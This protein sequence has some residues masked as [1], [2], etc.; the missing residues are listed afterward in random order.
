MNELNTDKMENAINVIG[1]VL[2]ILD[3][4][5]ALSNDAFRAIPP[6]FPA[7][8]DK[9][10]RKPIRELVEAAIRTVWAVEQFEKEI[11]GDIRKS[12]SKGKDRESE[13]RILRSLPGVHEQV[14]KHHAHQSKDSPIRVQHQSQSTGVTSP[15]P[16]GQY[17]QS[18]VSRLSNIGNTE[19]YSSPSNPQ[20]KTIDYPLGRSMI[21]G[22]SGSY[23]A[24]VEHPQQKNDFIQKYNPIRFGVVNAMSRRQNL[25]ISPV[26]QKT[27]DGD[28]YAI[29]MD[30]RNLYL[31]VPRFDLTFE[32]F[33]YGPGAMGQV[34]VCPN[35]DP[36]IHYR[37]VKVSEPAIFESDTAQKLWKVK[38]KGK[39]DLS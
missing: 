24:G 12:S 8:L 35:Y 10:L 11:E 37:R 28:Y 20:G 13:G 23:N 26:F 34:F 32:E 25:N 39:L 6:N 2:R 9:Q 19:T 29:R 5:T 14:T 18:Q 17:T 21:S 36:K 38:H 22:I 4:V 27:N 3:Q 33:S 30:G 16:R 1:E 31:V 7:K 15:L